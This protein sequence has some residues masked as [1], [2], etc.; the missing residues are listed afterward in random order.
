[1]I[2]MDKEIRIRVNRSANASMFVYAVSTIALP[3]CLVKMKQELGLSLTQA[4]SLG[5]ITSIE[6]LVFLL[7]SGIIAA[8]YGKIRILKSALLIL[9]AGLLL[10]TQVSTY[11]I[12][13]GIILVIGIGNAFLEALL[14]PL[15]EDL[16]PDDNGG[17]QNLLAAY[18][19]IGVLSATLVTGELLS[20]GISWRWIF[21]G[22]AVLVLIVFLFFPR[23]KHARL[24]KRK[25]DFNHIKEIFNQPKFYVMAFALFYAGAAEGAL[26][27]WL[28]T[29]IQL[30]MGE[31][32][33]AGGIGTA[34]F[35]LGM[36]FGRLGTSRLTKKYELKRII[37]V[38]TLL[39][40]LASSLF[41]FANQILLLYFIVFLT[42]LTIAC[43]W[44]SV[45]TYAVRVIPL[46][47]TLIMILLSCFGLVGFSTASLLMGIIGDMAGLKTSFIIVPVCQ[48][49]LLLLMSIESKILFKGVKVLSK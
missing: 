40:I 29:Y 44:P 32:P 3:I 33:R 7:L 8:K 21:A 5:F 4:G 36:F 14:I 10:F 49:F 12:A 26:T 13:L 24:P 18:W 17:K 9:A 11:L 16:Y 25:A 39:S 27:F 31:L 46:D 35:A 20:R 22:V 43:F 38:S 28:A 34:S 42:G 6:Q 23:T 45:Q 2:S 19:P 48:F 37:Q 15:V 1:M 41:F 30:D 47:A